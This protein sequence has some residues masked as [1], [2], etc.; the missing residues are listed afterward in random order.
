MEKV[1]R[2]AMIGCGGFIRHMAFTVPLA[3]LLLLCACNGTEKP[4]NPAHYSVQVIPMPRS[5]KVSDG[6]CTIDASTV[7]CCPGEAPPAGLASSVEVLNQAIG[8]LLSEPLR[9]S[10]A[11]GPAGPGRGSAIILSLEGPVQNDEG[12]RLGIGPDQ[13]LISAGTPAG[14]Y[15][16]VR[17]FIQLLPLKGDKKWRRISLPCLEIEDYPE[18]R[19]RGMHLDVSRHFFPADSIKRFIDA[20]A[21]YK[22]NVFHWHLTDDQG[23]RIEIK[24][25]PKLTEIGAWR[26]DTREREWS[27]DQFPVREGKPV[28]GGFYTQEEIREIVSYAAERFITIVPEIDV[29]G[30]SWAALYAYPQLSCSGM[31][32]FH[33]PSDPFSFTDPFCAGNPETYRLLE[34]VFSEVIGLFPSQYI[35]LGG[36]EAKK[37][38]WEGCD[39]CRKL[40][41][42][43]GLDGVE[44]LQSYFIS[45]IGGFINSKGRSYIGWDEILEGG[46]PAQAAVMSWRGEEGGIAAAQRGNPV[47]MVPSRTLYFNSC[48]SDPALEGEPGGHVSSLEDV[49]GYDPVTGELS[50]AESA[51]ILGVQGCLWTEHVQ[52]WYQVED[53]L[54]PRLLALSEIAWNPAGDRSFSEFR[55]RVVNHFRRLDAAGIHYFIPAPTGLEEHNAY[56][57]GTPVTIR[58]ENPLGSGRIVYTTDGS[59]PGKD[60]PEPGSGLTV[61]DDCVV[62]SAIVLPGGK[63]GLIRTSYIEFLEPV[64]PRPVDESALVKGIRYRYMEGAITTLDDLDRMEQVKEGV[65]GAIRIIPERSEDNFGLE[66]SG[67]LKI[68]SLDIYTFGTISDDG[69]RLFI[70]ER[71]LVDNDGIHGPQ[72]VRGQI[73]LSPGFHPVR[74]QFFEGSYGEEL[75]VTLHGRRTGQLDLTRMLFCTSR[76]N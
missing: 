48:Q 35:H 9:V 14:I 34:D 27:Y 53:H 69:S 18:F 5:V 19:W 52:T 45:R 23:W 37:S 59:D 10:T 22:M 76:A 64:A 73:G 12:Y 60:S 1:H 75:T 67:Y 55:G 2:A 6:I 42:A 11:G 7:I 21:M 74:V 58:L 30:H 3:L 28:Y 70:G 61:H 57:A 16:A 66:F 50:E 38:P 8:H 40:M 39:K 47:V 4:M 43:E 71:L 20:L 65:T 33:S 26:E 36:D 56:L 62:R 63:M 24:K 25:Y 68:D 51:A 15:Y 17:T 32:Y 31:P 29:P 41:D 46:L 44:Q 49:Y 13:V 72:L 54:F